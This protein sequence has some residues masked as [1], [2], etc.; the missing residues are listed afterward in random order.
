M[1][2]ITHTDFDGICCAAL[3]IRKY[4]NSI[5]VKYSTVNEAKKLSK[6]KAKFDYTCDLPKVENS[7]NIDHH[8]SNYEELVNSGRLAIEDQIDPNA[9]SATDLVYKYLNFENDTIAMEIRELGN[10]ADTAQLPEEYHP[11]GI[12]LNMNSDNSKILLQIST[13]LSKFG[14]DILQTDWIQKNYGK[15]QEIFEETREKIEK[16]LKSSPNLP[17]ILV[18][19]TR[20]II[21]GNL[22]KEVFRPLFKQGVVVI[23]LLYSKSSTEPIRVSFRVTKSNNEQDFYDVSIVAKAFNGGGHRMAAACTPTSKD[24]PTNLIQEL[25]K[26]T[27]PTDDIQYLK[28]LTNN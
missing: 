5:D 25:K 7:I 27:K 22:S 4:G 18:L 15:F 14:H 17:R 23:A 28:L 13:L 3:F 8:K 24:I 2:I 20:G 26:I 9:L 11:L 6:I 16:F 1:K 10:L 21:P 19:D 12:I